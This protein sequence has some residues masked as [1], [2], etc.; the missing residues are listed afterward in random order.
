MGNGTSPKSDERFARKEGKYGV[1]ERLVPAA[2]LP[3]GWAW[4]FEYAIRDETATDPWL[5]YGLGGRAQLLTPRGTVFRN[6]RCLQSATPHEI[7]IVDQ[8]PQNPLGEV[9]IDALFLE[10]FMEAVFSDD[11]DDQ[12]E[13]L[14]GYELR[15]AAEKTGV[16]PGNEKALEAFARYACI[17][18][19]RKLVGEAELTVNDFRHGKLAT[20]SLAADTLAEQLG[21][22]QLAKE[23]A[24]KCGKEVAA[25][26][27]ATLEA[28][29]AEDVIEAITETCLEFSGTGLPDSDA[30]ELLA[31]SDAL[32][33]ALEEEQTPAEK[34]DKHREE[35]VM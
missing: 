23:L 2:A 1:Y 28:G 15:I 33:A 30:S 22:S 11:L 32:K 20:S 27:K 9:G 6:S 29:R 26:I 25:A 34:T 3:D 17:E 19:A 12:R 21:A 8:D 4:R 5:R 14:L 16:A 18:A 10:P 7:A 24:R 35:R 31:A 13:S